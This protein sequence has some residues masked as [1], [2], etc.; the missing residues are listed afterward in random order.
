MK[1]LVVVNNR[2]RAGP[3]TSQGPEREPSRH[4]RVRGAVA[5]SSVILLFAFVLDEG[6]SSRSMG[7]DEAR[8]HLRNGSQTAATEAIALH[9][10]TRGS[11][12]A[13]PVIRV[14]P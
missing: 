3:S 12:S 5:A 8:R 7:C 4:P 1:R 2:E 14:P 11:A 13:P 6:C 9:A 10:S